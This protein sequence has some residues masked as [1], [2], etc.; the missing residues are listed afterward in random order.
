MEIIA[1]TPPGGGQD[2]AARAVAGLLDGGVRVTNL[3]GRGGGNA[4]DWLLRAPG[5]G[6]L[7]A[8][9]SPTLITNAMVGESTIDH[10]DLTPLALLYTEH[11]ALMVR[12]GSGLD[13]ASALL[14]AMAVGSVVVSFATALGSMNHLILAEIATHLGVPVSTVPIRVF[15]SAPLAV[16]DVVEGRGHL[17]VVSAVS[18]VPALRD[19]M[20]VPVMVTSPQRLDGAFAA[21]PTCV[22]L[23][24][25]C[26]RGTWRGLV[27]SPGLE[28]SVVDAWAEGVRGAVGTEA[29]R[30]LLEDNLWTST[31]L[32][33]DDTGR[34]LEAERHQLSQLLE[35]VGL[36]ATVGDG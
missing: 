23:G 19:G 10:R 4:W 7:A 21:T 11:S 15:D 27:G 5:A 12:P 1:G 6:D 18:A 8:V 34:F 24:V 20:L 28:R 17:A 32:G 2:R 29:W 14:D 30:R 22:E 3:P 26:V 35:Q 31:F 33:P 9:S 13:E 25:P 36:A 16:A